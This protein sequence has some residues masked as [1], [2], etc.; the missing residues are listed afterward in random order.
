MKK[1]M[2][3]LTTP[4]KS[5]WM[6]EQ[7]YKGTNINNI[8]ATLTIN[9]DVDI[10]KLN[11]AINVFVQRNKSFGL[12]FKVVDGELKQYFTPIGEIQFDCVSLKDEKAVK[13]LAKETAEEI[14]D[15]EVNRLF[16]FKLYKLENNYGGF[17][18]MTHHIISDAATM[19]IIAKEIIATI[20]VAVS[21]ISAV[22][23]LVIICCVGV[24]GRLKVR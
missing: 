18:V 21:K 7:F 6:M 8:C 15:I 4:Q 22:T 20:V 14:F 5:I 23:A 13:Q 1:E 2:F 17:V 10:Q 12:N 3:E 11:K 24:A 19:S 16:K 9:M